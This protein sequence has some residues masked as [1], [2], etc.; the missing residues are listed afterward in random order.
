MMPFRL[1]Q[2][3]KVFLGLCLGAFIIQQTLDQYF[4][5][6]IAGTFGLVP[7]AFLGSLKFW[8]LLTYP[9]LHSDVMHLILNLLMLVFLG[10]ELELSW[11]RSRFLTF[12]FICTSFA[13]F[14]YVMLQSSFGGPMGMATPLIG[15]S[16]GVYGLLMAYGILFG[17]RVL[18]F[19]MLFP[20]K[21]KHFVWI[22][23]G[24]ELMTSLFSGQR[25]AGLASAAHLAGMAAGFGYLWSR[26]SLQILQKRKA[27]K[28]ASTS[29]AQRIKQASHLKLVKG[30]KKEDPRT[31]H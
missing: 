27:K 23:A 2:T 8:Q 16:G 28:A 10:V 20:M 7:G 21:A 3:I 19:M 15:A 30:S 18:L 9:F 26:A 24:V 12:F 25:G 6:N 4:G 14:V 29:A 31:F 17:E 13:G 5:G 22:L 11:G 1:T